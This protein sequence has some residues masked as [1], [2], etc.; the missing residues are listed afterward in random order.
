[1]TNRKEELLGKLERVRGALLDLVGTIEGDKWQ[2]QVFSESDEWQV[3]DLL[4]H[5][6]SAEQ[7]MTRLVENIREGGEGASPDF[8]LTR[9]NARGVQKARQKSVEELT[10]ELAQNRA[11][12]LGV[13][14]S[15]GED[16]WDKK[17]RHGSLRI[18]TIEE[19][20]HLI[21][22]HEER[23]MEDIQRAVS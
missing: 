10:A 1:M 20:L 5:V 6:V 15:L 16:D 14:E 11:Y 12:L 4:R 13:I 8:D 19:I 18:M 2:Q 9:W 7:S 3:S 23:H 17:G 21:A 22:D